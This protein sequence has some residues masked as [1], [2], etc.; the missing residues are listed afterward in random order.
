[1]ITVTWH[2]H[3]GEFVYLIFTCM[4]GESYVGNSGLCC[5]LLFTCG[6]FQALVTPLFVD[7]AQALDLFLF[8]IVE[9]LMPRVVVGCWGTH[10]REKDAW[11]GVW[12]VT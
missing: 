11:S 12:C 6:V 3:L 1:M 7:S 5:A 4:P 9:I 10:C 2:I 8:P